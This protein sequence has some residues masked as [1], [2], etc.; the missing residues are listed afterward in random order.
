MH[1]AS[2]RGEHETL[3]ILLGGGEDVDQRD[4][5]IFLPLL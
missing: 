5:V 4:Q 3:K 2:I 1:E